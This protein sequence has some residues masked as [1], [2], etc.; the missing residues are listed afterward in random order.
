MAAEESGGARREPP[1][2]LQGLLEMAVVAGE[3]RPEPREPISEERQRWLHAAVTE[4]LG[5]TGTARAQLRRCLRALGWGEPEPGPEPEPR[6]EPGHTEHPEP[7]HKKPEPGPGHPEHPELDHKKPGPG[8]GHTEHPELDPELV[9]QALAELAELCESLDNA[10]DFCSLGG[11]GALLPLLADPRPNFRSGAARA[12]G[13]CAQNLPEAQAR[14]LALGALPALL[15]GLRGDP[16][17]KAAPALLFAISCLVRAQ[18]RGLQELE[19]LGGLGA[20]GEL[21]GSPQPPLR[22]RAAFLLHCLLR[23]HPRLAEPLLSQ[24]LVARAAALL[25]S[26]HDGAHEHGLG[27][28]WALA[29]GSPEGLRQCRDPALGLEPLLRERR[30]SLRGLEQFQEE[31]EFCERLLQLCFETPPEESAMDR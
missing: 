22:A 13:A 3:A 1:H 7:D 12:L 4:A 31:L 15:G 23:E 28:L 9:E 5:S 17:P 30:R 14:A 27:T 18:P 21:L 19:A 10:I 24:G 16:H 26:R 8:L 11:L 2:T 29:S 6:P 25:R 20:L